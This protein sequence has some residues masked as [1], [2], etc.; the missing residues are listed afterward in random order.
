MLLQRP[1]LSKQF[2]RLCCTGKPG[3][4]I[5]LGS[6]WL[7]SNISE[8]QTGTSILYTTGTYSQNFDGLPSTSPGALSGTGIFALGDPAIGATNLVGWYGQATSAENFYAGDG[9]SS[10]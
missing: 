9:S 1:M 5:I 3:L 4:V 6:V 10:Q 7:F 8:A 2:L